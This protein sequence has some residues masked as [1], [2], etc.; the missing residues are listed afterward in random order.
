MILVLKQDHRQQKD[1]RLTMNESIPYLPGL[2]PVAGKDICARFDGGR[3]SSDGGVLRL[4]EIESYLAIDERLSSCVTDVRDGRTRPR[5]HDPQL[6]RHD[7]G[8]DVRH[9]LRL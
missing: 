2:S 1:L 7:P 6:R 9:C 8:A 4:R 5:E 3:L